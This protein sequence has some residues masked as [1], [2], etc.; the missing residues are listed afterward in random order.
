MRRKSENRPA[1]ARLATRIFDTPVAIHPAKMDAI[2]AVIG[3]RLQGVNGES[4]ELDAAELQAGRMGYEAEEREYSV[5]DTG[6]AIIPVQGTLMKK[7]SG[8]M[9]WSGFSSYENI[10]AM[11]SQALGDGAVRGILL[12]IDSPGGETHGCFELS[13]LIYSSRGKKPIYAAANDNALSAAYAIASAAERVFV[14]ETGDVGS[15][16]VFCV[17]V[18]QSGYDTKLGVKYTY[19]FAGERKVDGNPNE[20]LSKTAKSSAQAKVDRQYG[21]FVDRVARNRGADRQ[22]VVDTKAEC[23]D[24][25]QALPLLADAVGTLDDAIAALTQRIS[26]ARATVPGA[27]AEAPNDLAAIA[28]IA[29]EKGA[30]MAKTPKAIVAG[31]AAED[32]ELNKAEDT[33]AKAEDPE[34]PVEPDE[35][36]KEMPME[37]S[38]A[39]A[40]GMISP[41]V[42]KTINN[43]CAAAGVPHLAGGFIAEGMTIDAVAAKLV[44]EQTKKTAENPINTGAP[45][46]GPVGMAA[47]D[48]LDSLAK[49]RASKDGISKATAYEKVLKENPAAYAAYREEQRVAAGTP[50][51][52]GQYVQMLYQRFGQ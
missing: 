12:D 24:M 35:D 30:N 11:F 38:K 49:A 19:I 25:S 2:L 48:S 27:S 37:E 45:I 4:L 40:T 23:L 13:D 7:C 17:H 43:M 32:E 16:G 42:A 41:K 9:G 46:P 47:L 26:G 33:E 10:A 20:P 51:I 50:A 5:T 3:P 8:L 28:A 21:M 1:L 18:D 44:S 22:A 31:S 52:Q 36:D 39:A 15:I 34:T 29:D 14:T 6:I